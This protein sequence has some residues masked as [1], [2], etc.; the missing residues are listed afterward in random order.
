MIS[1][2]ST[3]K[4]IAAILF[5]CFSGVIILVAV[6]LLFRDNQTSDSIDKPIPHSLIFV[7]QTVDFGRVNRGIEQG[8][9]EVVNKSDK[10]IYIKSVLKGCDCTDVNIASGELP[11]NGRR[12]MTFK[13][14]T[15]I[16]RG[17]NEVIINRLV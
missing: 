14:D 8:S 17:Q 6:W 9:V 10:P 4:K 12:K 11:P 7:P 15:R 5:F 13:W 16:R 3:G 2:C 1:K